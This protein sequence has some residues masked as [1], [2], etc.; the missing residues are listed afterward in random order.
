MPKVVQEYKERARARIVEA[1]SEVLRRKGLSASTM[2]AIAEEIG[3]SKGALYLYFPSKA[4][5]LEAVLGGYRDRILHRL[6]PLVE[7]GDVAEGIV[8]ALDEVFS[9]AF[10]PGLWHRV[11]AESA[12]D[13]EV[14]AM[15][16]RDDRNDRRQFLLLLRRLERTGRIPPMADPEATTDAVLLLLGGTL[17][18]V[19]L[20]GRATESRHRLVR[21]LRQVLG[22]AANRSPPAVARRPRR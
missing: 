13:P 1:A 7:R 17:V 5:L 15:L 18:Q 2:D 12:A 4:R 21:A 8:G 19:S 6:E 9:G 20:R 10:D 16:R 22:L 14:R 11:I 3:V